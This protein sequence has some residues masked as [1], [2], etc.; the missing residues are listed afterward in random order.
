MST[1]P[2]VHVLGLGGTIAMRRDASGGAVPRLSS[3]DLV[4][5]VPALAEVAEVTAETVDQRPGAALE[6]ETLLRVRAQA[7]AALSGGAA[8]VVITQGTDTIE[9]AAFALD[10]LHD[11]DAPAVVTG[12]MR[13]PDLTGADGPANLLA[14]VATAA[15][16]VARGLGCVV[17]LGDE[18]HAATRVAKRD[19]A[20]PHAFVSPGLGPLGA[21]VEQRPRLATRPARR[22]P[23]LAPDAADPIPAVALLP[24]A[25]GDDGR[26][27]EALPDLGYAGLVVE[28]FGAGHVPP[29]W[30]EPLER[31]A[32]RMPVVLASRT[33]A[34]PVLS[35]TYGFA[36]SESDLLA[37]GLRSAGWLDGPKARVALVL[38][39]AADPDGAPARFDEVVAASG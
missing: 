3:E 7:A 34:G 19:P 13:H 30:V 2:L 29:S 32:S 28:A 16:P 8:G 35:R 1:R 20:R 15:D 26:L 12:A 14:A 4:A 21:V 36:G 39:L 17:V 18:I 11:G 31:L 38:A 23:T 33:G 37:R 5:A 10:L 6:I 25:L 22:S 27:L 24:A 9:E